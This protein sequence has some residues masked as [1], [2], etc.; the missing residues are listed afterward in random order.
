MTYLPQTDFLTE[1]AK[2]NVPGHS[3]WTIYGK[4]E[5]IDTGSTPEDIWLAGGRYTGHPTGSPETVQLFSSNAAD[6]SAGTG[7][8]TVRIYGL[9]TSSSTSITTEDVTMN[10]VTA[11]ASVGTWYRVFRV[12][13]LTF[14]SG[15]TNAG[16][17]TCRHSSTTA[18]V[19]AA[20]AAG[21][22]ISQ[23]CAFTIPS[24]AKGYLLAFN[25][26]IS[27]S[28]GSSLSATSVIESRRLSSGGFTDRIELRLTGTL[29]ADIVYQSK[30]VFQASADVRVAIETV[31]SNNATATATMQILVVED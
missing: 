31:S 5:D 18:N 12:L 23:V 2:G 27:I 1:V 28:G 10:G 7:V 20:I 11:V 22:G 9:L 3:L 4:N 25:A 21:K 29:R 6:T 8:R 14:G 24:S 26:G 17:V 13:G 16:V 30:P 19:F 15:G